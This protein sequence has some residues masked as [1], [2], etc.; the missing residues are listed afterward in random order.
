MTVFQGIASAKRRSLHKLRMFPVESL[1][2]EGSQYTHFEARVK[3]GMGGA[4]WGDVMAGQEKAF[5]LAFDRWL[6]KND[7]NKGYKSVK[8]GAFYEI[9]RLD[10]T[11][12]LP[13]NPRLGGRAGCV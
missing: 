6:Y 9:Q 11:H 1:R 13:E 4:F 5:S 2:P 7:Y 10:Q 3:R 8:K 12:Q